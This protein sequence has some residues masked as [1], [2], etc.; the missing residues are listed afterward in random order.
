MG[1]GW[2]L[3]LAVRFPHYDVVEQDGQWAEP[4]ML[5]G[6]AF[7]AEVFKRFVHIVGQVAVTG[8]VVLCYGSTIHGS[9][10]LGFVSIEPL[11]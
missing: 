1:L 10:G 6:H 5:A 7:G 9:V 2:G 4:L 11:S 8:G 3:G